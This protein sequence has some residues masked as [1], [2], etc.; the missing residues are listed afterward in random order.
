VTPIDALQVINAVNSGQTGGEGEGA[1][2][3]ADAGSGG[4]SIV[5]ANIVSAL[6]GNMFAVPSSGMTIGGSMGGPLSGSVAS[7]S[8]DGIADNARRRNASSLDFAFTVKP[9]M[10]GVELASADGADA[11][12]GHL[13]D[14][15]VWGDSAD[16]A[17]FG[18]LADAR[19]AMDGDSADAFFDSL[20]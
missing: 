12:L 9:P 10:A 14:S 7:Q 18:D 3:T 20:G 8:G 6:G 2:D 19:S 17:V 1:S 15:G 4:I 13:L 11:H 5:D 16:D